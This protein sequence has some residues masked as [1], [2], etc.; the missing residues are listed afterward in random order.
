MLNIAPEI[1]AEAPS[2]RRPGLRVVCLPH[3]AGLETPAYQ[4]AGAAGFDLSAAID[5]EIQLDIAG[6]VAV[7]T[8]LVMAI[9]DGYEGQVRPRSGLALKHGIGCLNSP[10]TIDS[11]YRGEVKVI[12]VNLGNQ[13]FVIR[14][15]MRIAQL[16][17]AP[18]AR[19][20]IEIRDRLDPTGRGSSGFGS[21]GA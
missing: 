2:S 19:V 21:T 20:E 12:L 15:G 1:Q 11:D 18:V 14:R 3:F 16:V 9:P 13:P 4:S 7:P 5:E 10:G 17:I 8:G 6:R